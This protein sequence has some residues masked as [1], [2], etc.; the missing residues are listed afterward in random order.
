MTFQ[1]V[2]LNEKTKRI[3]LPY[4]HYTTDFEKLDIEV[5]HRT[6]NQL[7]KMY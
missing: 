4:N 6:P 3:S 7:L 5:A 2:E 1:V